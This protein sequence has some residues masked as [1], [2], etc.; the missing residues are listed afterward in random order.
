MLTPLWLLTY[1][2]GG[3]PFQVVVNGHTG[4][5]AGEHPLSW[6]KIF[7]AGMA[8]LIAVIVVIALFGSE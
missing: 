5:I 2:Y 8:A 6:V 4:K 3:K 1:Q 7:F